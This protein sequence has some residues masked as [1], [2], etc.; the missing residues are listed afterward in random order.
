M[1]Q[2]DPSHI[3]SVDDIE[4]RP[5][6]SFEE[7]PV[8]IFQEDKRVLRKKT[9]KMVKVLWRHYDYVEAIYESK[10]VVKAQ[11][12]HLFSLGKFR[13]QIFFYG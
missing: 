5:D 11:Y 13:G 1:I 4:V 10:S 6:V 8:K 12:P 3:I 2:S 7:E 9:I